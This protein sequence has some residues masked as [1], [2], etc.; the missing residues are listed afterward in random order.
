MQRAFA[1]LLLAP[2]AVLAMLA[3]S[4]SAAPAAPGPGGVLEAHRLLFQAIDKGDADAARAFVAGREDEVFF[5]VDGRGEPREATGP[6]A[7]GQAL[8]DLATESKDAGIVTSIKSWR[9]DC[10]S[11]EASWCVLELERKREGKNGP[12]V[13]RLRSTS[14]VQF[15]SN[16]IKLFHLHVSPADA[17][18]QPKV[19]AK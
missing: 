8:A 2:A 3:A 17:A 19:A 7:C 4:P 11:G 10:P 13:Q 5:W 1:A 6:K 12:E 9:A 15:T 16:G 14:L 18:S